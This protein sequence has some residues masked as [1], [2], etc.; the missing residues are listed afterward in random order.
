MNAVANGAMASGAGS[1]S[2]YRGIWAPW[3]PG[4]IGAMVLGFIVFWPI[5]LAILSYNLWGT[6]WNSDGR[7]W[8][9]AGKRWGGP[10]KAWDQAGNSGNSAFD[11]YKDETIKRLEQEEKDFRTYIEELRAAKDRDEFDR[12]M[13]SRVGSKSASD[14]RGASDTPSGSGF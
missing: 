11:A 14:G 3:A 7:G 10:R 8:K 4:A 2:G 13:N 9:S 1:K 12:F 6:W 5:G